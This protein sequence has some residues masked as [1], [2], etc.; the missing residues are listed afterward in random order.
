MGVSFHDNFLAKLLT[1]EILAE[2]FDHEPVEAGVD[3]VV[4]VVEAVG[5]WTALAVSSGMVY[6]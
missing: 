3:T 2:A 4:S 6:G 5:V 1:D